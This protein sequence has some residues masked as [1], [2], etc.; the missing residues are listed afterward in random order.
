MCAVLRPQVNAVLIVTAASGIPSEALAQVPTEPIHVEF[1]PPEIHDPL[2]EILRGLR[3]VVIIK[4]EAEAVGRRLDVEERIVCCRRI[5]LPP[6]QNLRVGPVA[7]VEHH[8]QD[9]RNAPFVTSV[10]E[11]LELVFGAVGFVH[12]EIEARIVAPAVVAIELIDGHELQ[13]RDVQFAQIVQRVQQELKGALLAEVPHQQFIDDEVFLSGAVEVAVGP[14][15]LRAARLEDAD[16]SLVGL[17][18]R[19]VNE[20]RVGGLGDPRVIPIIQLLL[21]VGVREAVV[22]GHDVVLVPVFL[23]GVDARE[24]NPK[25]LAVWG[26]IHHVILIDGPSGQVAHKKD[27]A[28]A[29]GKQLQ[30]HGRSV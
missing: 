20:K 16:R 3:L 2:G 23:S 30:D 15:K 10:D 7:V 14:F 5:A 22:I 17:A 28:L 21:G 9:H 26:H 8:V 4:E 6:H 25:P 29:R 27:V 13:C 24:L 12:G 19:K 1:F 18:H 11:L